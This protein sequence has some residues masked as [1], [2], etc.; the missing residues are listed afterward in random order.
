MRGIMRS[1][2]RCRAYLGIVWFALVAALANAQTGGSDR[3]PNVIDS[4][5]D[6]NPQSQTKLCINQIISKYT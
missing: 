3:I 5:V 4:C 6:Q 1:V 2:V